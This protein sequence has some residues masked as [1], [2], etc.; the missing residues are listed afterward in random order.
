MTPLVTEDDV[1]AVSEQ[2]R[3]FW[4]GRGERVA[5]LERIMAGWVH[6]KHAVAFGSGTAALSMAVK[7][8]GRAVRPPDGCCSAIHDAIRFAGLEPF[9]GDSGAKI[10]I[11]PIRGLDIEDFAKCL[12]KR[13]EI[14]LQ[15]RFGVF[16]F[17]ALKDVSG[18]IGGC[19]VANEP[20]DGGVLAKVSPLSD[21]NAAM[22][23]SQLSRYAGKDDRLVANGVTWRLA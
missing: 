6:A 17:G 8:L 18:G 5:A 12:P 10:T 13:H 9:Y 2:M 22:I 20:L 14:T 1:T 21:I 23:I 19:L 11:Y 16:S 7:L 4:I 3:S 15:G